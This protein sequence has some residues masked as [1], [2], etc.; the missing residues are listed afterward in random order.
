MWRRKELFLCHFLENCANK[1]DF[2]NRDSERRSKRWKN[3]R[4]FAARVTSCGST[5]RQNVS[6]VRTDRSTTCNCCLWLLDFTDKLCRPRR[7]QRGWSHFIPLH[8]NPF[9]RFRLVLLPFRTR[10]PRLI[11]CDFNAVFQKTLTEATQLV[12][13]ACERR[14][15]TFNRQIPR[16]Y[17][18][19]CARVSVKQGGRKQFETKASHW[20]GGPR[21]AFMI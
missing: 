3:K 15:N 2:T 13:I 16:K 18:S 21:G 17:V 4:I 12:T 10:Q 1:W 9:L 5:F 8:T 19:V 20:S 11:R 7:H 6:N 14:F